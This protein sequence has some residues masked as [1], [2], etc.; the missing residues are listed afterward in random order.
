MSIVSDTP[1]DTGG[2]GADEEDIDE[3]D[4][5]EE[6]VDE[7][8][9][10]EENVDSAED[11]RRGAFE[12][13]RL[14]PI[15]RTIARRLEESY[16][17]AVH[18]TVGREMDVEAL[19]EA[20]RRADSNAEIDVSIVDVLLAALSETLSVHTE[21]NATFEDG[22]H[23][24]YDSHHVAIA[25]DADSGLVT[26][27][28]ENVDD[29]SIEEIAAER[30]R[31][32]DL[33]L[34]GDHSMS[35][36]QGSTLTVTNLGV[37]GVDS[38]TPIINPPEVAIVGLNRIRKRPIEAESG[39]E[40]RRFMNVELTFDHRPIDGADAARF[41]DTLDTQLSEADALIGR[42]GD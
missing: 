37:L 36:L 40:F 29:R 14:G 16:R 23:R 30:R 3:E 15:R 25:V 17:E 38:F 33:V 4:V 7:E 34:A 21:F 1:G 27:V 18:V 19:V 9:V 32:T 26:P 5:D 6:D 2:N 13:R 12:D 8:N 35:D 24:R 31:L 42:Q 22:V 28:I 39:V 10:D 41:L 11:D 20:T